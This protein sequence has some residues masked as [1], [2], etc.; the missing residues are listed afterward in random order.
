MI[1][2]IYKQYNS[3][4][5]ISLILIFLLILF[6]LKYS[7]YLY[8]FFIIISNI[9]FYLFDKKNIFYFFFLSIIVINIL[10]LSFYN[11]IIENYRG[12]RRLRRRVAAEDE[13]E[14][15]VARR[16]AE[17]QRRNK[18]ARGGGMAIS[19]AVVTNNNNPTE[20]IK[21]YCNELIRELENEYDRLIN[22]VKKGSEEELRNYYDIFY[23]HD[24]GSKITSKSLGIRTPQIEQLL[25]AYAR[26]AKHKRQETVPIINIKQRKLN[27]I[28]QLENLKKV[29]VERFKKYCIK[30]NKKNLKILKKN[31]LRNMKDLDR[32]HS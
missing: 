11:N 7:F 16:Q 29:N 27:I 2:I 23:H 17:D 5:F 14:E 25:E 21:P 12:Q 6:S 28:K 18:M 31:L 15:E 9:L 32:I 10:Y 3:T 30:N 26:Q 13:E 8:L 1:N 24:R 4:L 22:I 19:S 20:T